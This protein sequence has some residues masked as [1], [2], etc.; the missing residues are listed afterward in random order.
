MGRSGNSK[1]K[2][3]C[4]A[5]LVSATAL[6]AVEHS[7]DQAPPP[8]RTKLLLTIERW[9]K[10]GWEAANAQSVFKPQDRLRFRFQTS[11]SGYL[12][13]LNQASSGKTSWIYPLKGTHPD[14]LTQGH[15]VIIPNTE[16]SFVVGGP[17]GFDTLYWIMRSTPFEL[18]EVSA[19]K[20]DVPSTLMSRCPEETSETQITCLDKNAGPKALTDAKKLQ[21]AVGLPGSLVARDLTFEP[22][23]KATEISTDSDGSSDG[24]VYQLKIAHN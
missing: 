13:I 1:A 18:H 10:D 12:Y 19:D 4:A 20:L 6:L 21:S 17:P 8:Q 9:K 7:Q 5:T 22:T 23:P 3:F 24:I 11:V 14:E 2:W 15:E 16:G